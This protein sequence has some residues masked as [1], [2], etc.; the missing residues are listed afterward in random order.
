MSSSPADSESEST[1]ASDL[2][3]KTNKLIEEL[4]R[5]NSNVQLYAQVRSLQEELHLLQENYQSLQKNRK[6]ATC[7]A[8]CKILNETK[9]PNSIDD[10]LIQLLLSKSDYSPPPF[11]FAPSA[12]P[13][14]E[15]E[16]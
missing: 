14:N 13:L 8:N 9:E 11:A 12:P 16:E 7:N 3:M 4:S 15:E 5:L 10:F 2:M 1:S 6:T